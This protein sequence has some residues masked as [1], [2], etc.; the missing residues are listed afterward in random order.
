[1]VAK[2][3]RG[4]DKQARSLFLLHPRLSTAVQG[5]HGGWGVGTQAPFFSLLRH[6]QRSASLLRCELLQR[7][8]LH[9]S[10]GRTGSLPPFEG[11]FWKALR[12]TAVLSCKG[13]WG[14]SGNHLP[15]YSFIRWR[16][17]SW[18]TLSI[19]FRGKY[20]PEVR[21]RKDQMGEGGR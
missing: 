14:Y 3:E 16:D 6:S 1:M 5:Q 13:G 2:I 10:L 20:Q 18:H 21:H 9:S 19:P 11:P 7:A 15:F 17:E 8:C 12:H 4:A